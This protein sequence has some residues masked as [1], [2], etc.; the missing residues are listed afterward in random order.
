MNIW[1]PVLLAFMLGLMMVNFFVRN[2]IISLAVICVGI[3]I[4]RLPNTPLM[5][6]YATYLI[7]VGEALFA[8]FGK[9][10]TA[11]R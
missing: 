5:L 2:I 8:F 11:R 7:M 9:K 1:S 3:G 6:T 10:K 4:T